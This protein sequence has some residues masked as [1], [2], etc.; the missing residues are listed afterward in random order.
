MVV[1]GAVTLGSSACVAVKDSVIVA[2]LG[3]GSVINRDSVII[4]VEVGAIL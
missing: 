1:W 3:G 2:A 4:I